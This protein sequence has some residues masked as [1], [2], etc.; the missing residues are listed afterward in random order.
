M[1]LGVAD[2]RLVVAFRSK[3][4]HQSFV[5]HLF[6]LASICLYILTC[7]VFPLSGENN[8]T[9]LVKLNHRCDCEEFM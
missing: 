4:Y 1:H 6:I 7:A 8:C 5:L 9:S 2:D 3:T